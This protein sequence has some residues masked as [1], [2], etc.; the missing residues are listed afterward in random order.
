MNRLCCMLRHTQ[1]EHSSF[2]GGFQYPK[3]V[4][5]DGTDKQ[6]LQLAFC[7]LDKRRGSAQRKPTHSSR[8]AQAR[9]QRD[10][11]VIIDDVA[12]HGLLLKI[13]QAVRSRSSRDA[14]NNQ[15]HKDVGKLALDDV[16]GCANADGSVAETDALGCGNSSGS[17]GR[18]ED[19]LSQRALIN[20]VWYCLH[21]VRQ[22][23]GCA[24]NELAEFVDLYHRKASTEL[25]KH[26]ADPNQGSQMVMSGQRL[27]K[28]H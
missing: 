14:E 20:P 5:F 7:N 18:V 10:R 27:Q 6:I 28:Y 17:R 3:R 19:R 11:L 12:P 4:L 22:Q 13:D 26:V 9:E 2:K 25:G 15:S 24:M 23:R 21:H 16:V 1:Q 8:V